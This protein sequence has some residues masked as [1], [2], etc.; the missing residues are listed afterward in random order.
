MRALRQFVA[1][2]VFGTGAFA[3][4]TVPGTFSTAPP[5]SPGLYGGPVVA[6]PIISLGNG[7]SPTV[8]TG[9]QSGVV[10]VPQNQALELNGGVV[11]Q[12]QTSGVASYSGA[13][14]TTQGESS[15][16]IPASTTS[17]QLAFDYS[18]APGSA[19]GDSRSLGEIADAARRERAAHALAA[20]EAPDLPSHS[21]A[22]NRQAGWRDGD[23]AAV[24]ARPGAARQP[25]SR[26]DVARNSTETASLNPGPPKNEKEARGAARALPQTS[27][28]LPVIAVVGLVGLVTGLVMRRRKKTA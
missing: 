16:V 19:V 4:V 1:V 11:S 15:F 25:A 8:V 7:L 28:V 26:A 2:L 27:T 24:P 22:K 5:E 12:Q 9:Q 6:T 3:Q 20:S 23:A 10:V 21:P 18:V 17:T 14:I 13:G